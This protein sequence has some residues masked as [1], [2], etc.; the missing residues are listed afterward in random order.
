MGFELEAEHR[1]K[2][3]PKTSKLSPLTFTISTQT[4]ALC[5]QP[6]RAVN[7]KGLKNKK[8]T[9]LSTAC[10]R[11]ERP[12]TTTFK[13]KVG[14]TTEITSESLITHLKYQSIPRPR[15]RCNPVEDATQFVPS[16]VQ[17]HLGTEPMPLGQ[18]ASKIHSWKKFLHC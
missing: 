2:M 11:R 4:S 7:W 15:S 3:L 12:Q 6:S 1:M 14:A 16:P 9:G 10:Q 8:R 17:A 18:Q 5:T 13:D